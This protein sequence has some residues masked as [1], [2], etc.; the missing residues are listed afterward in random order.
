MDHKILLKLVILDAFLHRLLFFCRDTAVIL[1]SDIA[2]S[3][4]LE[5]INRCTR[6][7]M[8]I[9]NLNRPRFAERSTPSAASMPAL[10]PSD[11]IVALLLVL[12]WQFL[13]RIG[14]SKSS[15]THGFGWSS[16]I[17]ALVDR[18]DTWRRPWNNPNGWGGYIKATPYSETVVSD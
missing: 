6:E 8:S 4:G 13:W 9:T 7:L 1:T 14:T 17:G 18:D 5:F 12:A 10:A 16:P 2:T 15:R 11:F 3:P